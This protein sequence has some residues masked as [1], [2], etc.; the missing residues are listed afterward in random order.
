[1]G[2]HAH[3]VAQGRGGGAGGV[4]LSAADQRGAV[5]RGLQAYGRGG[6]HEF[7]LLQPVVLQ[8]RVADI[9]PVIAQGVGIEVCANGFRGHRL[10]RQGGHVHV[11]V[12]GAVGIY[13]GPG[14]FIPAHRGE[15]RLAAQDVVLAAVRAEGQAHQPPA[16]IGCL[17]Q[18]GM[19]RA[20]DGV[21]LGV[22]VDVC[23]DGVGG[24]ARVRAI[25]AAAAGD[26]HL[27]A[28]LGAPLGDE[29]VVPA[30]FLIDMR[31]F[32]VAS[33]RT[34][35]NAFG[36][37]QLFAGHRVDLAEE[38]THVRVA[39][40]VALAVF[41]VERGVDAAL[42]Q[43]DGFGP[44]AAR[45]GG[46]DQ[47]IAFARHVGRDHVEHA[48]IVADGGGIDAAPGAGFVQRQLRG[49]RQAV[50]YLRPVHQ[51][52]AVVQGHAGEVLE[53]AVHQVEVVA[54]SAHAGVGM[55]TRDDG[56]LIPLRLLGEAGQGQAER[57]SGNQGLFFRHV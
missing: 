41:E 49:A 44:R 12:D 31:A 2:Q 25:N 26:G 17:Y 48:V 33:A 51:V 20:L 1:M 10:L 57:Q 46:V 4:V 45:V 42:L 22:H 28:I 54:H 16:A 39:Y 13:H 47:E 15:E 53:T 50:A 40:Q 3:F 29:Q 19:A 9:Y 27:V 18:V 55:I 36:G 21:V 5:L 7:A 32:R 11:Q 8:V 43:P 38:D 24:I 6:Q 37:G 34:V 35:P 56:V 52:L 30:V 23:Q 14:S